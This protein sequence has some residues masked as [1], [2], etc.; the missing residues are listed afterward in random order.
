MILS[1]YMS[2]SMITN[3]EY[4]LDKGRLYLETAPRLYPASYRYQNTIDR[5][6]PVDTSS[7]YR[8]NY[9]NLKLFSPT[10]TPTPDLPS[11]STVW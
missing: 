9:L 11:S 6:I 10:Q 8:K 4:D 1:I 7:I 2:Y 5:E 3:D